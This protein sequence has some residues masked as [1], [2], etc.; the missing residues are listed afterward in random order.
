MKITGI[1]LSLL[2]LLFCSVSFAQGTAT[3]KMEDKY[4]YLS[5]LNYIDEITRPIKQTLK[6]NKIDL[7]F[8]AGVLQGFDNNVNLDPDRKKDG[9]LDASLNTEVAYNYTDDIRQN[10]ESLGPA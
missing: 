10:H 8:F 4:S 5:V 3:V 7:N 6:E 9:F 2:V 1:I